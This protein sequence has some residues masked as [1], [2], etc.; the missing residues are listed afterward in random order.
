MVKL[1]LKSPSQTNPTMLRPVRNQSLKQNQIKLPRLRKKRVST[2]RTMLQK[3]MTL[4]RRLR[5]TTE[6]EE[7]EAPQA[8]K[9][10]RVE[11][12]GGEEYEVFLERCPEDITDE[13]VHELFQDC[14]EVLNI[15][16]LQRDGWTGKGFVK[17]D[18]EEAVQ[19]AIAK[20]GADVNGKA[21]GIALPRGRA[22]PRG[23][24]GGGGG[25]GGE[26]TVFLGRLSDN[27]KE[28]DVKALFADC[29]VI[30]QIRWGTREGAFA[31][32]G[33]CEFTEASAVEKALALNGTEICGRNIAI[34]VAGSKSGGGGG[35]RG[36]R[37]GGGR[38]G[39]FGGG[40]GGARGGGRGGGFGGRGG[41]FGGR[42]G[43]GG[44]GRGGGF[45]GGR[46]GGRGGFSGSHTKF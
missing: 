21:I 11:S 24:G 15:K 4:M 20:D 2:T 6:E 8:A 36:G 34:D 45:G 30:S 32:Y 12:N 1:S 9:K 44:G 18:S 41:G 14:G 38:G 33:F 16:W 10:P 19:K 26:K 7:A 42:G 17:L 29:G 13:A 25:G 39:G 27:I 40:F 37:G 5:T 23:G 46:G 3:R 28:E 22:L 35:G 31:G 43:R